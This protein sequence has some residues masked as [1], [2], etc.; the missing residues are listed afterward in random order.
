MFLM[1]IVLKMVLSLKRVRCMGPR[2]LITTE[3]LHLPAASIISKR[4]F[5]RNFHMR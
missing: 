4:V 5:H 1:I 2:K 3:I